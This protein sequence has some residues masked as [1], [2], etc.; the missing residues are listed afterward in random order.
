MVEKV[1]SV[2]PVQ[3]PVAVVEQTDITEKKS[4]LWLW[5]VIAVV[6]VGAVAAF[7]LLR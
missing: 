1:E 3:K 5:I 4:K 7:L 6:V 2:A